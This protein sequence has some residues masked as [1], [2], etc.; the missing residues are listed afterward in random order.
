MVEVWA[1][2]ALG[3]GGTRAAGNCRPAPLRL[4]LHFLIASDIREHRAHGCGRRH[5]LLFPRHTHYRR[6][7]WKSNLV[8]LTIMKCMRVAKLTGQRPTT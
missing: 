3:R 8:A 6:H 2:V 5:R 4:R 7:D 1:E